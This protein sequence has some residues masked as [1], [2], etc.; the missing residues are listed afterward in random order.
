MLLPRNMAGI[1]FVLTLMLVL[2]V[3]VALSQPGEDGTHGPSTDDESGMNVTSGCV[4]VF[5]T[6]RKVK[7]LVGNPHFFD[8]QKGTY[9]LFVVLSGSAL[10]R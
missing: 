10:K 4:E 9:I 1:R 2:M 6:S 8:G 3:F 7:T 5:V